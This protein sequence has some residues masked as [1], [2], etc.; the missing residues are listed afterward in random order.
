MKNLLL[1]IS[2][3]QVWSIRRMQGGWRVL[4]KLPLVVMAFI[5]AVTVWGILQNANLAG[6]YF[7]MITPLLLVYLVVLLLLHAFSKSMGG[8]LGPRDF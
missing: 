1:R 3:L 4:A 8:F 6:I 5:V 2:I 7:V